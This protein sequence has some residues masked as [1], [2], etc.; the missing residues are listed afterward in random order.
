[1]ELVQHEA[2]LKLMMT[3]KENK[4][5]EVCT[6]GTERVGHREE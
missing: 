3:S 6:S 2:V 1:M 5:A 4:W